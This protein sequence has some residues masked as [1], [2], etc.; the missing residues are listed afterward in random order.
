MRQSHPPIIIMDFDGVILPSIGARLAILR[1]LKDDR[2]AWDKEQLKKYTTLD[3]IRRVENINSDKDFKNAYKIFS[4][5]KDILPN[6]FDRIRFLLSFRYSFQKSEITY[7]KLFPYVK[8]TLTELAKHA[9]IGI[10]S[11]SEKRRIYQWLTKYTL[12]SLITAYST[13]DDR[14]LYGIKPNPRILLLV[15]WRIKK[16]LNFAAPIDKK[17]VFFVGDNVSDV[18][19]AQR[20]GVKSIAVLTGN[21]TEKELQNA[22][23]DFII[24]TLKEILSISELFQI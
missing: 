24:P 13:R 16:N 2:Y 18:K 23:P 9:I 22:N 12:S 15:L 21:S 5:F 6:P 3:L 19:T 14:K 20:A 8:S 17:R 7:S 1:L 11:N 10:C 4:K